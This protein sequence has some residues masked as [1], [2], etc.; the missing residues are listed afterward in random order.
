MT[1]CLQVHTYI[2]K[3]IKDGT[4][5]TLRHVLVCTFSGLS[6]TSQDK[7][8]QAGFVKPQKNARNCKSDVKTKRAFS[9]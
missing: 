6:S 4:V 7:R 5:Y 3:K 2:K 8:R 9:L 1:P